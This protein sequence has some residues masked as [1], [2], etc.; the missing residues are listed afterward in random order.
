[1]E[2]AE[3]L[4][5]M[6]RIAEAMYDQFSPQYWVT[7][8]LYPNETH[9]EYLQKFLSRLAPHSTV[10][11]AGCGAGRYDGLLLAA[12]HSVVGIDQSA[13]MLARARE[14]FPQAR[15]EQMGLQEMDFREA[16][17]G[18]ICIDALEHVCP[19]DWPGIVQ[20]FRAALK[21]GAVLY[22]TVDPGDPRET[23]ES[24]ARARAMGLPVVFGE[25]ADRV[26]ETWAYVQ[27]SGPSVLPH[28]LADGAVYHYH[29]S[30][31]QVRAWLAQAGLVIEEQGTGNWYEHL[32]VRKM[33]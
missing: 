27:A 23:A 22:F 32:I 29:P 28:E 6:R 20:G 7:F 30:L 4:L 19:E 16:F 9:L 10:L 12:G 1:M 14:H 31:E 26:E 3:W 33:G 18:V 24:Y 17:D 11:S 21:P 15:Y 13:G 5:H 2:R 25:V 8:G